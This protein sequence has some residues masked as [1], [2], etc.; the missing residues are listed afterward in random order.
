MKVPAILGLVG[1]VA[2]LLAAIILY[3]CKKRFGVEPQA[4]AS[5]RIVNH[6]EEAWHSV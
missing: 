1:L 6:Q 3:I 5:E 4:S 2:F